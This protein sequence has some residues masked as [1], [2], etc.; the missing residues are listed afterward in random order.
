[1]ARLGQSYYT[2]LAARALNQSIGRAIR[3]IADYATIVLLDDRYHSEQLAHN[4]L[5][6]W[7]AKSLQVKHLLVMNPPFL[8]VKLY[9]SSPQHAATFG[10]GVAAVS[11]F[12]RAK[13]RPSRAVVI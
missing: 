10:Q 12:F 6:G 11:A 2:A 13:K 8:H 1:M 4:W 9:T 5:P 3:H 7:M